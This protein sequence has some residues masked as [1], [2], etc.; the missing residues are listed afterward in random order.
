MSQKT[1]IKVRDYLHNWIGSV[2]VWFAGRPEYQKKADITFVFVTLTLPCTQNHTDQELKQHALK[3]FLQQMERKHGWRNWLWVAETQ[4]NDNLHFHVIGDRTVDHK[5]LRQLWNGYMEDLGYIQDYRD[6]QEYKHR[7]GFQFR[8]D[9]SHKWPYGAQ[10]EAYIKGK[11]EN[12]SN[13]N[14]TD[15]KR[16]KH[17]KNLPAYLTKYICKSDGARPIEGRLWGCSDSIRDCKPIRLPLSQKLKCVFQQLSDETGS[18]LFRTDFNW[19]L[20]RFDSDVLFQAYPVLAEIWHNFVRHC[21]RM[22]YPLTTRPRFFENLTNHIQQ[23][24]LELVTVY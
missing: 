7:N 19:T 11:K 17:V 2:G 9:L 10:V 22:L 12:W 8:K 15:I 14:S 21:M 4:K 5:T 1:K 13:P 3:P 20:W 16:I 6:A 24:T 23:T 18:E